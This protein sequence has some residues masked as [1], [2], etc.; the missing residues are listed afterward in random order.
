MLKLFKKN[1][2][3]NNNWKSKAKQRRMENMKLKK[4][5]EEILK[6]RNRW[7]S[8]AKRNEEKINKLNEELKKNF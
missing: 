1:E 8:K 3:N 7:K 2:S 6:S 4:R 5:N